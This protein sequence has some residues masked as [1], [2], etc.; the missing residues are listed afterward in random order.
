MSGMALFGVGAL[1]VFI[2]ILGFFFGQSA[3]R[4]AA[5]LLEIGL[6]FLLSM[7]SLLFL[8]VV[9]VA[10]QIGWFFFMVYCIL[11]LV[12][13]MKVKPAQT[14]EE[15]GGRYEYGND[16]LAQIFFAVLMM[17]WFQAYLKGILSIA[18]S[19]RKS[20]FDPVVVG[21]QAGQTLEGSFSVVSKP[22]FATTCTCRIL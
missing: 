5:A 15:E 18:C 21:R 20:L 6:S 13:T 14:V 7:P 12:S 1:I 16:W 3:L 2:V 17:F 9:T 22:I 4:L 19:H 11:L 8:A 10:L